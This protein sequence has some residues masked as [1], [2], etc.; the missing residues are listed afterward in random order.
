MQ[1]R[2]PLFAALA[3]R[4]TRIRR[5]SVH[6]GSIVH[7]PCSE[8]TAPL[9]SLR[10]LLIDDS[11]SSLSAVREAISSS[12]GRSEDRPR[13]AFSAFLGRSPLFSL[14]LLDLVDRPP[15]ETQAGR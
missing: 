14:D 9:R 1:R 6:R 13:R 12:T 5:A 4:Q 8:P 3:D 7:R 10:L 15:E 2:A 11:L